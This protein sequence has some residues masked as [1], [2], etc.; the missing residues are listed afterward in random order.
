MQL[1][2]NFEAFFENQSSFS[3]S[4][5]KQSSFAN[6]KQLSQER[7]LTKIIKSNIC[8]VLSPENK[9]RAPTIEVLCHIPIHFDSIFNFLIGDSG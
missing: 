4:L 5:K 3:P 7:A 2:T 8:S 1:Q 9:K 6:L